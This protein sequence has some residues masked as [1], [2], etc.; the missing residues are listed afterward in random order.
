MFVIVNDHFSFGINRISK[1]I[2]NGNQIISYHN[3]TVIPHI[4]PFE[5]LIRTACNFTGLNYLFET[6]SII[7]FLS[8]KL[9]NI[10]KICYTVIHIVTQ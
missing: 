10:F 6:K 2:T 7:V 4:K 5:T 1:I 8:K 3:I 9:N